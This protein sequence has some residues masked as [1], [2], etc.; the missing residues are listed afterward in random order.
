[1]GRQGTLEGLDLWDDCGSWCL[2]LLTQQEEKREE[3]AK[4]SEGRRRRK[5][6]CR[7]RK[8]EE[9]YE[10]EEGGEGRV[11]KYIYYFTAI[12]SSLLI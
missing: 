9:E 5:R 3:E 8:G 7:I 4:Q 6:R 11:L 12:Y 10:G 2:S 1:M